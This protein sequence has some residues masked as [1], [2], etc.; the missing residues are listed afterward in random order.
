MEI[1]LKS[2]SKPFQRKVDREH[3]WYDHVEKR[4]LYGRGGRMEF[5][6][7]ASRKRTVPVLVDEVETVSGNNF[8]DILDWVKSKAVDYQIEVL[9][10]SGDKNVQIEISPLFFDAVEA[11]LKRHGIVAE[12]STND[13]RREMQ[14]IRKKEHEEAESRHRRYRD[15]A[16]S[17]SDGSKTAAK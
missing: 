15:H 16:R 6:Y 14:E 8:S 10:R 17:G 5:Q 12:Y 13:Y 2:S 1:I 7:D 9:G 11:D 3:Y 4:M